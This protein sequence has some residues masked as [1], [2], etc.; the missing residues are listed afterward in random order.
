MAARKVL[1]IGHKGAEGHVK[2]NTIASLGA[3]VIEF[4]VLTCADGTVVCHHDPLVEATGEWYDTMSLER[5]RRHLP[6]LCT[7]EETLRCRTL[8]ESTVHLYFDLKHTNIVR[9]TLRAIQRAVAEWGWAPERLIVASFKQRELLEVNAW[10]RA[11]PELR[12]LRTAVI[13]DAVPVS[14]ARDFEALGVEAVSVGK[15]CV[16]EDF[17]VDCHRRGLA[18]WVWTVNSRP[19]MERLISQGVDGVCSDFPDMV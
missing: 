1:N 19:L 9:P 12:G 18:M 5:A 10:R 4:D 11:L 16:F 17:V 7:L 8:I 13:L 6:K 15:F 14:L 2:G 3:D